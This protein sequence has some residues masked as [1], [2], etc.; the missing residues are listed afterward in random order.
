M[1]VTVAVGK[2]ATGV[3]GTTSFWVGGAGHTM[4]KV[5][6]ADRVASG[7]K[8]NAL[9]WP[10]QGPGRIAEAYMWQRALSTAEIQ[11]WWTTAKCS[12]GFC[13]T[14]VK[15][16]TQHAFHDWGQTAGASPMLFACDVDSLDQDGSLGPKTSGCSA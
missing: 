16:L 13:P 5:G 6:S 12:Y 1:V 14:Q 10:G 4:M 11:S 2:T 7:T 3:L 8:M 15:G 9:G